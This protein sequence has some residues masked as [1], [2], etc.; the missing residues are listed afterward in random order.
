MRMDTLGAHGERRAAQQGRRFLG[1]LALP[2]CLALSGC[3]G[4][5]QNPSYF[6]YLLPTGDIIQTHAKPIGP[7]YYANFDPHAVHLV[8]RP[9]DAVNPV[10]TQ[11]VIVA[12]VLDECGQP[13]R[14]RRVEWLVEGVGNIIE[15]DESGVFPGRGYKVSNKYAVSYTDYCEHHITRGNANPN[16]DFVIRP[17]QTWC[18]VSSAVEGDTHVT[19]YAPG[20]ADWEKGRVVV[21]ARWVDA[22]WQ[23]PGPAVAQA[24]TEHVLTTRVFRPTDQQPLTNY[25]IRYRLLGDD[26]PALFLPGRAKEAVAV[27]DQSGNASATLVQLSPRPGVNRIGI[28]VIRPPDPTLPSGP[29]VILARGETTVEWQAPAVALNFVG[30]AVAG[31]GQEL[32]YTI[33]IPNSGKMESR[34]MTVTLRVPEGLQ[35]ERA[36]PPAVAVGG[37]LVWTLGRLPVGQAHSVEVVLKANRLGTFTPCAAVQTE[38]GLREEKCLTTQI[39]QPGLKVTLT[40]PAAG[41]VGR[42]ATFQATIAN[43]GAAPVT[44]VL[45]QAA[46]DKGL[47]HEK[48]GNS[49][50]ARLGDLKPFERRELPPLVLTPRQLG[51]FTVRATARADGGLSD[52]AEQAIQVKQAQLGVSVVGP[53]TRQVGLPVEWEIRVHNPGDVPVT[54]VV[55]RNRLPSEVRFQSSTEGGRPG[56]GEVTWELGALQPGAEKRVRV[57]ATCERPAPAAVNRAEA[58]AD[59]GLRA[60]DEAVTA[61]VGQA[62]FRFELK[63]IGDPVLVGQRLTYRVLVTNTGSAPANGVE[64]KAVVPAELAIVPGGAKGPGAPTV[65][66]QVVTFAAVDNVAP[67]QALEYTIEVQGLRK[68]DVRF[69]AE[70]RARGLEPPVVEEESTTVYEA[71][72]DNGNGAQPVPAAPPA[73]VVPVPA[74]SSR[75]LPSRLPDGPPPPPPPPP[76]RQPGG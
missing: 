9:Q 50:D 58:T 34:S 39:T 16:D 21:T 57:T 55:L 71:L 3:F 27:S 61:I 20:I 33:T 18:V 4:V 49:M 48:S 13:R 6:P 74:I 29:S 5:T 19:A 28:E 46:F 67:Q 14:K 63:D 23:F 35:Y 56:D 53:R 44:N 65:E 10:R 62:A 43:T 36:R 11:Y 42:P 66:K 25:R 26:P 70:L 52:Q 41:V 45:V 73:R 24:G 75:D 76:L 37:E 2:L 30:P 7:G 38:E 54:G 17:G 72:P 47:D 22:A 15:V 64:V 31:V 1:L 69:R 51:T 60:A 8:V 40:G 59:G 12:T 32:P 68:G